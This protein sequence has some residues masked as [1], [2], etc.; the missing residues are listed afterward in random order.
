MPHVIEQPRIF[1]PRPD[2]K[3]EIRAVQTFDTSTIADQNLG[4][5]Q[6]LD[7]TIQ[8]VTSDTPR[9]EEVRITGKCRDAGYLLKLLPQP[10]TFALDQL[11]GRFFVRAVLQTCDSRQ[12]RQRVHLP[13]LAF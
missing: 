11:H 8:H 10:D 5:R 13:W 12:F 2:R 6:R 7:K 3:T 4:V 9:E 1:G